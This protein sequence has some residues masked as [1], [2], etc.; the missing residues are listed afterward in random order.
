MKWFLGK[1]RIKSLKTILSRWPWKKC[2]ENIPFHYS[3]VFITFS[4]GRRHIGR[5]EGRTRNIGKSEHHISWVFGY[6]LNIFSGWNFRHLGE[7]YHCFSS[8]HSFFYPR[9]NTW[10]GRLWEWKCKP[11]KF[12]L[13]GK[14]KDLGWTSAEFFYLLIWCLLNLRKFQ[15]ISWWSSW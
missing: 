10:Q 12:S 6:T 9:L 5:K 3:T 13:K 14:N 15:G 7:I 1:D 4:G 2:S 8:C 11:L